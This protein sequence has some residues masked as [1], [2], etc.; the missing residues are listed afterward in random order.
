MNFSDQPLMNTG[1]IAVLALT[2][3]S[4][5]IGL[6]YT[7]HWIYYSWIKRNNSRGING[8]DITQELF[9]KKGINASIKSSFFYI[10]YWNHNKRLDRHKLRP[11][12]YH[13]RSVWTMMEASQQ[14]YATI[15]RS[16][17]PKTFWLAFRL[18]KLIQIL[19]TIIS[20]LILITTIFLWS[21]NN[22][23]GADDPNAPV[24]Q[25]WLGI[26]VA[27]GIL[28]AI[29]LWATVWRANILR[30]NVPPLLEG[31]LNDHEIKVIKR[32]FWLAFLQAII[33]SILE[34][35]K[36]ILRMARLFSELKKDKN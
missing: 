17:E 22:P 8:G 6:A 32:I 28:F 13:R 20:F 29:T 35:L 21:K 36:T 25:L 33:K 19:G 26:S 16:S 2:G 3:L 31:I 27:I 7:L 18:P 34:T 14:A 5:L 15:I 4:L 12:T 30:K 10:K 1:I 24:W 9:N 23:N 11:W